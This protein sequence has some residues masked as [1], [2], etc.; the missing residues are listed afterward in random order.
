[1]CL[2]KLFTS[3]TETASS[4]ANLSEQEK[5][6]TSEKSSNPTGQAWLTNMAAVIFFW[7][8]NTAQVTSCESGGVCGRAVNTSNSKSGVPG[9]TPRPSRCFLR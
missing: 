1:M 7:N 8:T 2:V 4:Y 6:S 3:G 9:L 5:E